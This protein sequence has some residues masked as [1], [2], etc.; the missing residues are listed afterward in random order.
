MNSTLQHYLG[1]I[2]S[3][4]IWINKHRQLLDAGCMCGQPSCEWMPI[5]YRD[6]TDLLQGHGIDL[7]KFVAWFNQKYSSD[8]PNARIK[9]GVLWFDRCIREVTEPR[10]MFILVGKYLFNEE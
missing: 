5:V 1:I 10:Y 2:S 4:L 7:E 8:R 6:L 3:L 9:D